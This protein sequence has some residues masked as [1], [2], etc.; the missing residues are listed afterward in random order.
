MIYTKTNVDFI[1]FFYVAILLTFYGCSSEEPFAFETQNFEAN[2]ILDCEFETCATFR[3]NLL[4]IH[5]ERPVCKKINTEIEKVACTILNVGEN[6]SKDTLEAAIL[7]FNNL[8]RDNKATFPDETPSYEA[9][10]HAELGFQCKD[11]VSIVVDSYIFTGGAHGYG[12]MT[13][14]NIE[15]KTGNRISNHDL[16]KNYTDF[17]TYAEKVF[18]STFNIL[19]IESINS[20]GFFF[21]NNTFRL[22][23][24]IGCTNTHVILYYNPYE[25][26][27][28]ADGPIE[29]K[30]KKEDVASYFAYNIL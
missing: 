14:L 13:F 20:T 28:Y 27:S 6:S 16:F 4:T 5:N 8:Y 22:P 2:T 10:I 25:I 29:I 12:S 15:T 17:E 1:S 21:E 23:E 3:I 11:I 24:N 7:E 9:S 30:I 26:S 19:E 18:R